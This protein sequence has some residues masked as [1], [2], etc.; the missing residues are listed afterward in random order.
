M[1]Q[2]FSR[3]DVV[4]LG[5][6]SYLVKGMSVSGNPYNRSFIIGGQKLY[7]PDTVEAK[8]VATKSV[9]TSPPSPSSAP[10]PAKKY[11][12]EFSTTGVVHLLMGLCSGE[13]YRI[14]T[15]RCSRYS[16]RW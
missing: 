2:T 13:I 7:G 3:S 4:F 14:R 11:I 5:G 12:D 6:D 1:I 16:N 9:A 10:V 15:K 8:S